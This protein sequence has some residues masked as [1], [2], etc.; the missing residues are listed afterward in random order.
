MQ[1]RSQNIAERL[2]EVKNAIARAEKRA[3]RKNG[4]VK[5]VAVSKNHPAQAIKEACH[6]GQNAF[7][8]NYAQEFRDKVREI[9]ATPPCDPTYAPTH[10]LTHSRTHEIEWHF[11][12]HLQKNKIKYV[13]PAATWIHS[14]D[15]VELLQAVAERLKKSPPAKP[16]NCLIE[17]SIAEE[18]TKSGVTIK[19]LPELVKAFATYKFESS[20]SPLTTAGMTSPTHALKLCGLM[21]MPPVSET[22]EESRKYFRKL[23]ELL[24]DINARGIYPEPLTELSMGMSGD[25]EV[26]IEEGATLVRIGTLIF[27]ERSYT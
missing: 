26:A 18:E 20:G 24:K 13:L 1:Q 16:L 8:E 10:E 25:F 12:G 5:L 9:E 7:G 11:L 22:P 3:G 2:A 27:G 17:V 15:S 19:E 6:A 23:A 14:I 21:C 4:S